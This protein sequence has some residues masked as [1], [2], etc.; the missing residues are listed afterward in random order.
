MQRQT[1][2][3]YYLKL[4][5]LTG[6]WIDGVKRVTSRNCPQSHTS[7]PHHHGQVDGEWCNVDRWAWQMAM[8]ERVTFTITGTITWQ[9]KVLVCSACQPAGCGWQ[10]L[11]T[12]T[13]VMWSDVMVDSYRGVIS[14]SHLQTGLPSITHN[15]TSNHWDI[16]LCTQSPITHVPMC[17]FAC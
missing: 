14:V 13:I 4:F 10:W 17:E 8:A 2:I 15:A 12:L 3:G 1:V 5:I 7:E 6:D 16:C 11:A 9:A